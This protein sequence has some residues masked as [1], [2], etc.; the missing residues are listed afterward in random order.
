MLHWLVALLFFAA[1]VVPLWKVLPRAGLPAALALVGLIPFG[2]VVLWWV[3][4]FRRWPG[5]TQT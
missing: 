1:L 4:A 3:L 2:A 5:D